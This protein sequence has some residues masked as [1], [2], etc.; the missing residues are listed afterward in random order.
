MSAD[1]TSILSKPAA[2]VEKPKPKPAGT[3]LSTVAGMPA[4]REV[5]FNGET[6]LVMNFKL[7]VMAPM[8]DVSQDA[9]ADPG[10]GELMTWPP[11]NKDFWVGTPEGEYAFKAFLTDHLGIEPGDKTLGEMVAEAPGRQVLVTLIHKPYTDKTTGQPEIATNAGA[12]AH[13]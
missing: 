5:T 12:T 9:L 13:V 8:Q 4:Q 10:V 2:A 6:N 1:F 11:F 7:K 3:Y